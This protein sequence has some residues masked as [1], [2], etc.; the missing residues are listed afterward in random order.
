MSDDFDRHSHTY[1]E[2][3]QKAIAFS[4]QEAGF[5]S[6]VK[7]RALIELAERHLG[8]AS[9]L[10]VLD[11]GC[12]IGLTD[13]Y[14]RGKFRSL[15]GVD[16][17]DGVIQEAAKANPWADYESYDGKRLPFPD[18]TF[19]L[20]FAICVLHHVVPAD[21]GAL[22]REMLRVVRPGGLAVVIEQNPLNP[23]TRLAV[24]RCT[25]DEGVVLIGRR[26]T[27]RLFGA[28]GSVVA[29]APYIIFFPWRAEFFR[30]TQTHLGWLPLGAQYLVAGRKMA[31]SDGGT[32]I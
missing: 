23:L 28:A 26:E 8:P 1:R 30:R 17:S 16:T 29:E 12:G 7:A 32:P 25:F 20:A 18:G 5:F 22:V 14:L 19:G 6:D 10:D 13:G 4:G 31:G 15:Q 3:L 21:R 9:A 11:V 2:D 27:R 24:A